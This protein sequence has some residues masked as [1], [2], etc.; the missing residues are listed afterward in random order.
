[1]ILFTE[2]NTEIYKEEKSFSKINEHYYTCV[3]GRN[4]SRNLQNPRVIKAS[5][6][7][8]VEILH[9]SYTYDVPT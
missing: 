9:F 8:Q 2:G 6:E 7:R 4:Q 5:N 3:R 1:M